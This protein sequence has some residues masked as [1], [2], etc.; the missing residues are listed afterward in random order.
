MP[1]GRGSNVFF[2]DAGL[3]GVALRIGRLLSL[4]RVEGS[5]IKAEA[6][7]FLPCLGRVAMSAGLSGL[8][9]ATGIPATLGGLITMNGGSQ[10]KSIGSCVQ[11]VTVVRTDGSVETL[12]HSDCGFRYRASRFRSSGELVVEAALQLSPGSRE[13]VRREVL[14]SLAGTG[15]QAGCRRRLKGFAC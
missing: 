15:S 7:V 13:V 11:A 10:R 6:G 12:G 14:S 4:T 1:L 5:I 9:H 2:A 3:R 8:E